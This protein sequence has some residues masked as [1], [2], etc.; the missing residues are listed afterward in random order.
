MSNLRISKLSVAILLLN[1]PPGLYSQQLPPTIGVRPGNKLTTFE[2]LYL[3]MEFDRDVKISALKPGEVIEGKLARDVYSE[4]KQL[5]PAGSVVRLAVD[6]LEQR[7]RIPNDHW[8]WVISVFTPRHEKYPT[9][10]SAKVRLPQGEEVPLRVSFVSIGRDRE[11]HAKSKSKNPVSR[12]ENSG[13]GDADVVS[14]VKDGIRE[15]GAFHHAG[16]E[17]F[18]VNFEASVE[19]GGE[20]LNNLNEQSAGSTRQLV[21][22]AAGTQARV[23]LLGSV[24]AS[25]SREGDLFQARLIEPIFHNSEVVI[26][27]GSIVEGRVVKRIPPRILSRSGSLMLSFT[28]LRSVQGTV[29]PIEASLAG[30]EVDERSRT[31]LNAEGGLRGDRPGLGWMVIN[32]AATGGIAKLTDDGIQL[33]VELIV[34][35]ATDVSTA[36]TARIAAACVSGVFLLTRHGRDVVL[37]KYTEMEMVFDR[38]VT[39]LT[40]EAIPATRSPRGQIDLPEIQPA[41]SEAWVPLAMAL[42]DM[43]TQPNTHPYIPDTQKIGSSYLCPKP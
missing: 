15:L 1:L 30:V 12:P 23:I 18:A 8:P 5:F 10:Q 26:P 20:L 42:T 22:I 36:G 28:A 32:L 25:Q 24:S 11:L 31:I 37:P 35:S 7:R 17:R 3:R 29:E 14:L 9:F 33:V 13:T 6:K 41:R 39:L 27:E 21:T 2:N 38:P 16:L 4:Y 40:P 34:S 19:S 43:R